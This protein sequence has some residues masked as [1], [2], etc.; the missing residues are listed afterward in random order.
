MELP[1]SRPEPPSPPEYL[2]VIDA[3]V[4]P[5]QRN[6]T[7]VAV[8]AFRFKQVLYRVLV[9][10]LMATSSV[11][12]SS[13]NQYIR[14]KNAYCICQ[15][16]ARMKVSQTAAN[17]NRLFVCCDHDECDFFR[18][19]NPM[20]DADVNSSG[21]SKMVATDTTTSLNA[22]PSEMHFFISARDAEMCIRNLTQKCYISALLM[23]KFSASDQ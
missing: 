18:W 3:A 23:Q 19:F 1:T 2:A 14:Y 22:F 9:L 7:V 5:A 8:V 12:D 6:C 10:D 15:K 11:G 4:F 16:V 21:G 20:K 17:Q 13:G